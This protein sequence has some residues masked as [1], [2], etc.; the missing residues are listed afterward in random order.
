MK[1]LEITM[2]IKANNTNEAES[3]AKRELM[4]LA[5]VIARNNG[6]SMAM[7]EGN[8]TKTCNGYKVEATVMVDG[9]GNVNE[10]AKYSQCLWMSRPEIL[11]SAIFV[12]EE[13]KQEKAKYTC[14]VCGYAMTTPEIVVN[15]GM[16]N[17]YYMC[18]D[19]FN[20]SEI[21]WCCICHS[22]VDGLVENP[23]THKKCICPHCGDMI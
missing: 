5:K 2:S 19:C 15:E 16:E 1:K 9:A 14:K 23:V 18:K 7:G 3:I 22:Y 4:D 13:E 17:E 6:S 20:D 10:I 12:S 11:K 8:A 21:Q